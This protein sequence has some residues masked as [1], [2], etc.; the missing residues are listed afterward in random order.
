[1][2]QPLQYYAPPPTPVVPSTAPLL[3]LPN[4][5]V[6]AASTPTYSIHICVGLERNVLGAGH[7]NSPGVALHFVWPALLAPKP[8]AVRELLAAAHGLQQGMGMQFMP[9]ALWRGDER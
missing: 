9:H 4:A 8:P 3:I 1:M 7:H 6:G 5:A 2:Y